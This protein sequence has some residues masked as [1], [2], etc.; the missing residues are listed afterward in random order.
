MCPYVFIFSRTQDAPYRRNPGL[1]FLQ[2]FDS[3]FRYR[4]AYGYLYLVYMITCKGEIMVGFCLA[5]NRETYLNFEF[6][7]AKIG[8]LFYYQN[9]F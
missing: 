1:K 3:R 5:G 8:R 2:S 7:G 9:Y 6:D 4:K